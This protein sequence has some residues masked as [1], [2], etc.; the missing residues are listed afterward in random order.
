MRKS[1]LKS[2]IAALLPAFVILTSTLQ[3]ADFAPV[4]TKATLRVEYIYESSGS[5]S[6]EG[7][8]D[9]YQWST[10]RN[11]EIK[12]TLAA[13]LPMAL[14]TMQA[15]DETQVAN[16]ENKVAEAQQLST[17]MA[18][19]MANVEEIM[20]KCGEDEACMEREAM[21]MGFA[22]SGTPEMDATMKAGAAAQ[23][24]A[25]PD[26]PRYQAWR[27]TA[28]SGTYLID[29]TVHIS[30][31]DPI[32]MSLPNARCTRDEVR[33]G[34]GEISVPDSAKGNPGA[35]AGYSG[36]EVDSEKRTMAVTLPV[37]MFLLPY[38]E[39]ITT[40]EPE[41]THDTP[42]P[43]GPQQQLMSFRVNAK[44]GATNDQALVVALEGDWHSQS[45]EQVVT[46]EGPLREAGKLTI[47]WSFDV[48]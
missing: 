43:V 1:S 38:T 46:L 3:A 11:V 32:C 31:T 13:Q 40:D 14:P 22:M 17:D 33:T 25:K 41:G 21:A 27:S 30:V 20:A 47:R 37:P 45:G 12:A 15:M 29:E 35:T 9:P 2:G 28:Q 5:A 44:G 6:S 10:K 34:S 19:M 7:G 42:T 48:Q 36:V 39:T 24:L 23:E 16:L 4:D 18:P 8:Y 26:A